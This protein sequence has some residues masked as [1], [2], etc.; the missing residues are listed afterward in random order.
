MF[1]KEGL[2]DPKKKYTIYLEEIEDRNEE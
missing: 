2:I 1:I